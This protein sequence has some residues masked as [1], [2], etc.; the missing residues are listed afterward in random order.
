[1]LPDYPPGHQKHFLKKSLPVQSHPNHEE[2][3]T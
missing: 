2:G 1:V 3:A